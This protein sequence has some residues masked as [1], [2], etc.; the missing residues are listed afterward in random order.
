MKI[1]RQWLL[2]SARAEAERYFDANSLMCL[3]PR[4]TAWYAI[5]LLESTVSADRELANRILEKL[6]VTDG[7]HS[8]CT[9]FVI[10]K[11]YS[12]KL[13]PAAEK[14]ILKNLAENL[15]Q[16]A[17]VRYSDGNVNHPLAAWVNLICSGDLLNQPAC[18]LLGERLLAAFQKTI[19]SRRHKRHKQAEM[20]EY[21]SPTYT[22][23]TLWFLAVAAEFAGNPDI[24]ALARSLEECLWLNVAMHWHEPSQ[25][26]AGPFSR[27]YSE[28]SLGGFSALHCT[29][30]Y[31]M[32]TDLFVEPALAQRYRHPSALIENAFVAILNF[33]MPA[34]A[35]RM[36]FK[37]PYP[38]YFRMTTYCEQYHENSRLSEDGKSISTFDDDVYPGGWGDL[39]TYL[40]DEYCLGTASR[41]YVNAGHSDGFSLRYRRAGKVASL[42]D[43][44]GVYTRMVFNGA[45][46][47][48]DNECH[49]CGFPITRDY[50]YE[51]GRL[52]SYQHRNKAIVCY[53]PKRAG[54]LAVREL[55]LDLI[56]TGQAAFDFLSVDRREVRELPF[57]FRAVGKI[58]IADFNT[59]IAI[60]PIPPSDDAPSGRIWHHEDHLIISFY[61]YQGPVMDLTRE[62]MSQTRNGFAC[63]LET[64]ENFPELK[65]FQAY[66]ENLGIE[67]ELTAPFVRN[68][69]FRI[70]A[71]EMALSVDPV[72]ERIL[73]RMWN[74]QDD[75]VFHLEVETPA[76]RSDIFSPK[77]IYGF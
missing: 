1:T 18:V 37:K 40:T 21:N 8:P 17:M 76:E 4:E 27:A 32:Q 43:F 71:D 7:T 72:S 47:G 30:G 56:F 70:G 34:A 73:R 55:R 20:S 69:R 61:N 14:N 11:R 42:Q 38:Y 67:E 25:Q 63:L 74:G 31:A 23:L 29:F 51:E 26:F 22:A 16:S 54:H 45:V 13:S 15:P 57:E 35:R 60:L 19:S 28:D 5:T 2:D 41:P 49:V 66:V 10:Y 36:A 33:N 64:R 62:Q 46:V 24:K 68:V 53:A 12:G 9:L 58:V 52:F 44:R 6:V 59:Y 3:I 48:Q 39:T 65:D 50:L 77:T 75:A